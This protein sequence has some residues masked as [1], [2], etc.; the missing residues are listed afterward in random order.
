MVI[1][2]KKIPI[3]MIGI[4]ELKNKKDSLTSTSIFNVYNPIVITTN[5]YYE[6]QNDSLF[7][8]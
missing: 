2:N 7:V 3:H 8:F 1:C 5:R 4:K 6:L